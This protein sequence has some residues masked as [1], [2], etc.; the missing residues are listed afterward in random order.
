ME[1]NHI[2]IEN[3]SK[4]YGGT[5]VYRNLNL[6]LRGGE[7]TC[8]LG[9]SGCGKTTV[10]NALAGLIA[11]EGSITG[12]PERVSYVFQEERLLPNLT[13]RQNIR[14]VLG[15]GEESAADEILRRV[16]LEDKADCYP[17]SLSGGQA[18]RA[19]IAR[20]F[21]YPS[22]LLLMDEPFSSL[23]TALKIRLIEVFF[24]LWRQDGRTVVFVTHD[25]EEAYMLAHRAVL[26]GGGEIVADLTSETPPPRRYGE[27][28][29][30]KQK[31][32]SAMLDCGR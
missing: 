5:A 17:S 19:A 9:A 18:R 7:I 16:E 14:Y 15:K 27:S 2:E 11:Y 6:T 32:L 26:L 24:N 23:D 31:I 10:L 22:G 1:L 21:A 8:L 4:T 28:S 30:F 25:V 20:A 3:F 13:V 29:S 12:V